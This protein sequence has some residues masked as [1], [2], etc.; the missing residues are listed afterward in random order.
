VFQLPL[1]RVPAIRSANCLRT[2]RAATSL[3]PILPEERGASGRRVDAATADARANYVDQRRRYLIES[4]QLRFSGRPQPPHRRGSQRVVLRRQLSRSR[5]TMSVRL[6]ALKLSCAAKAHGF[7]SSGAAVA[8]HTLDRD[9][10][11]ATAVSPSEYCSAQGLQPRT[12]AGPRQLQLVVRRLESCASMKHVNLKLHLRLKTAVPLRIGGDIVSADLP[13]TALD[14]RF[15]AVNLPTRMFPM[16]VLRFTSPVAR[17]PRIEP[18]R[19]KVWS[20]V[21]TLRSAYKL[22][23]SICTAASSRT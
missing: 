11:S 18:V 1:E 6:T 12:E 2:Y 5:S 3:S 7:K 17:L 21:P 19:V 20:H 10:R 14:Y 4:S 22:A 13:E 8:A 15:S 16:S 23:P 9:A